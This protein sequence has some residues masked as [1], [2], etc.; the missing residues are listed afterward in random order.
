MLG[1][2]V[3]LGVGSGVACGAVCEL[4]GVVLSGCKKG[5]ANFSGVWLMEGGDEGGATGVGVEVVVDGVG[6]EVGVEGGFPDVWTVVSS[7]NRR[8]SSQPMSPSRLTQGL[9]VSKKRR[10][11]NLSPSIQGGNAQAE[12]RLRRGSPLKQFE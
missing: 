3:S 10:A 9:I 6:V 7:R 8:E 12:K 4:F 1:A 11:T 2:G 5:T